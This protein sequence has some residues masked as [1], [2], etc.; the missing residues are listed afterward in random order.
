MWDP[1]LFNT[2][3]HFA[4]GAHEGQ[5]VNG[6]NY[7][8]VVHLVGVCMEAMRAAHIEQG[9]D[10]NL[11]MQCSL[12]HDTIE[13]TPVTAEILGDRFGREIAADIVALSREEGEDLSGYL[14]RIMAR[15]KEVWMVKLA[16]RICNL[17][18]P[19]PHWDVPK[20]REYLA[21][22]RA[23]HDALRKASP[24]LAA[25]LSDKIYAYRKF[26]GP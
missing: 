8:Y 25:R 1:D 6:Q 12:L 16:D 15:E 9:T 21:E 26:L 14:R 10:S 23:I 3:L 18:E 20:R 22:S 19:P 7:S 11:L 2:T 24:Y 5:F 17:Q 4:A 13:D